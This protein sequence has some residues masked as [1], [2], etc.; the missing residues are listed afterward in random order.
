MKSRLM[1]TAGYAA[2]GT[3]I[4]LSAFAGSSSNEMREP[5]SSS[6]Y[7]QYQIEESTKNIKAQAIDLF[8][9]LDADKDGI[10]SKDEFATIGSTQSFDRIDIDTDGQLSQVEIFESMKIQQDS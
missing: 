4:S 1:K 7:D 8:T 9:R 2:L 6:A 5:S 10:V 3:L